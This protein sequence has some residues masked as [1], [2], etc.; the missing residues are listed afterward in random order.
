MKKG[1][2]ELLWVGVNNVTCFQGKTGKYSPH[3]P[4]LRDFFQ[5][6]C[7]HVSFQSSLAQQV[8]GRKGSMVQAF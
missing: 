3:W 2:Q 1:K 4:V 7:L 6:K 8:N 5:T